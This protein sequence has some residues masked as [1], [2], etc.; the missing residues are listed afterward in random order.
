MA[1]TETQGEEIKTL[2]EGRVLKVRTYVATRNH[3]DTLDYTD[4]RSTEVTEALVYFGRVAPEVPCGYVRLEGKYVNSGEEIPLPARF[5]WIDCT[6]LFCWRGSPFRE[7]TVDAFSLIP[8]QELVDDYSAWLADAEEK[9]RVAEEKAKAY[10]A[11][12]A[13]KKAEEE[14]NRPVKGK[15]MIV[16]KGRKVPVGFVGTVAFV[17]GSGSVLLKADNEWQDRKAQGTW[18]AASNLRAR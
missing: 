1:I 10:A 6:N 4:F 18:V 13:V 7:A 16:A 11:A 2:Y 12:Q 17:S 3:S 15:K 8:N 9:Q 5:G 14:K